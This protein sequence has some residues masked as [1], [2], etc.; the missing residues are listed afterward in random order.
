M[1]DYK[2]IPEGF[3]LRRDLV[4]HIRV[5]LIGRQVIQ[6]LMSALANA[7]TLTLH[8]SHLN[9]FPPCKRINALGAAALPQE[10]EMMA[11]E[12][13][14]DEVIHAMVFDHFKTIPMY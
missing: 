8:L 12:K 2:D 13:F 7:N 14:K 9:R 10:L 6:T 3:R 11:K 5:L 1:L 4:G